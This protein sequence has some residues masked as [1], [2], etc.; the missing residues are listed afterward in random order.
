M[1]GGAVD[2]DIAGFHRAGRAERSLDVIGENRCGEAIF[3]RIGE[4]ER[5][6]LLLPGEPR[7]H[8]AEYL[9]LGDAHVRRNVGEDGRL[10]PV[11]ARKIAAGG[12]LA[13]G[14]E[15]GALGYARL[16]HAAH[17]LVVPLGVD[18]A[19]LRLI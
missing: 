12:A 13:A 18:R 9:L 2:P 7:Q 16:D 4:P 3:S 5:L 6:L 19:H 8:R 15:L 14:L 10:D 11:A 17:A 1:A